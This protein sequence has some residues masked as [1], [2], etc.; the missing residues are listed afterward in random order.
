MK[1]SAITTGIILSAALS[2]PG[3]KSK[4]GIDLAAGQR[5][6]AQRCAS[7]HQIGP[8][9]RAGFA[10]QLNGIVGRKAGSTADFRYSTAMKGSGLVWTEQNL[11]AF[12]RDP[13]EVV[14]GTS[15]RFWGLS[16]E[17]QVASLVAWLRTVR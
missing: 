17:Q 13:Q 4:G 6:F 9:A 12:I 16:D 14:P 8:Y 2:L 10:P 1:A 3:C 15:M 11:R 5:T 7:C